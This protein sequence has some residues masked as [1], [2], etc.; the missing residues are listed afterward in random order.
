MSF[1]DIW[2]KRKSAIFWYNIKKIIIQ[3]GFPEF[4][5]VIYRAHL[6]LSK[7]YLP[8]LPTWWKWRTTLDCEMSNITDTSRVLLAGSAE[9]VKVSNL[10]GLWDAELSL[11]FPS[12]TLRICRGREGVEP[13]WTVRCRTLPILPEC[14][15]PDLPRSWRWRTTLDCEMPNSP[16]TSRVLLAGFAEVVKVT[17]HTGLWD[18]ELSR[19]FPS[20]THRICRGCEADEHH[21][22]VTWRTLPILPE[23]YSPDLPRSWRWRTTL[24]CEM[25][26]S[27]DTSRVPLTDLLSSWKWRTTLDWEM[28]GSSDTLR[29]LLARLTSMIWNTAS[30]STLLGPTDLATRTNF[31]LPSGHCMV[32]QMNKFNSRKENYVIV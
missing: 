3:Q 8:N 11:Y 7:H 21:W 23:C 25:P 1:L 6:I 24:D 9:V 30:K 19:Y 22:T 31:H 27:P 17:N 28:P 15:S 16:D 26:N 13:H 4:V 2:L 20:A 18:A 5:M 29:I 14:Y 32:D 10:T 12:A